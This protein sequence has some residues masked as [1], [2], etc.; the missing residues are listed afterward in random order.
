MLVRSV[1]DLISQAFWTEAP[2]LLL[3]AYAISA[4]PNSQEFSYNV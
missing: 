1:M 2:Q 4:L 3:V